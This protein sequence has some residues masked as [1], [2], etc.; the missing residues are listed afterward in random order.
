MAGQEDGQSNRRKCGEV[1]VPASSSWNR[2]GPRF[3]PNQ[4]GSIWARPTPATEQ[5]RRD[6]TRHPGAVVAL[7]SALLRGMP[8]H[9]GPPARL[10]DLSWL[11]VDGERGL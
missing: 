3:K 7:A 11:L 10:T 1:I 4:R 5:T 2:D 6:R 9:R 8:G